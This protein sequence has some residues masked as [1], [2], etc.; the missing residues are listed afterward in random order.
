LAPPLP[1]LPPTPADA[2]LLM[3]CC[4]VLQKITDTFEVQLREMRS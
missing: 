3:L 1:P 4:D 2:L